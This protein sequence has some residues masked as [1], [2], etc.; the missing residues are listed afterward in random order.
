MFGKVGYSTELNEDLSLY[1]EVSFITEDKEF[2]F[3]DLSGVLRL[4]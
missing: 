2:E 4:V 1:G 3:D